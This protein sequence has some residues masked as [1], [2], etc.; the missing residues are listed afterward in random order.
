MVFKN[1]KLA[2][3]EAAQF[4]APAEF[5]KYDTDDDADAAGD[6]ERMGGGRG[7]PGGQP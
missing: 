3:P 7:M 4:E 2:K 6:D 5:Q 1:V